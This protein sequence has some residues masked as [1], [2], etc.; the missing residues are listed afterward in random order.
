[1]E[2][3]DTSFKHIRTLHAESNAID[4]A[5]SGARGA[6][7]YVT[8]SPCYECAKRIVNAGIVAVLYGEFYPSRNSALVESF[9]KD[10]GILYRRGEP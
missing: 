3:Y 10:A 2:K 5:G 9:F 4:Q 7:L 6:W 8:V 1:M